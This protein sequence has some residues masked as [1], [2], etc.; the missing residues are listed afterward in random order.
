MAG[1]PDAG[2]SRATAALSLGFQLRCVKRGG[3]LGLIPGVTGNVG[4]TF[5]HVH[6]K[7]GDGANWMNAS[8]LPWSSKNQENRVDEQVE[9]IQYGG[10]GSQ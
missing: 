7:T 8:P 5:S 9:E 2:L 10:D 4:R 3:W 1:L 6:K